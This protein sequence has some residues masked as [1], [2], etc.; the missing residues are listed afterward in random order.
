MNAQTT[1]WVLAALLA[2]ALAG[3]A[4]AAALPK[5]FFMVA[6]G[7]ANAVRV[8]TLPPGPDSDVLLPTQRLVL[9]TPSDPGGVT[10]VDGLSS[11]CDTTVRWLSPTELYLRLSEAYA[12]RLKASDGAVLGGVTLRIDLHTD[13]VL[14]RVAGPD[15]AY[16][17]VEIEKC[18]TQDWGLYL[19]RSGDPDYDPSMDLGWGDPHL[20]GGLQGQFPLEDI[21]WTGPRS[22]CVVVAQ[23]PF[24]ARFRSKVGPVR[25]EWEYDTAYHRPPDSMS[26]APVGQLTWRE[27][28]H[29]MKILVKSW[30]KPSKKI[31]SK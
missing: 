6:P 10:L 7:R 3:A 15:G 11:L 25:F 12:P 19:R 16:V 24:G 30:L 28:F 13:Q 29:N 21:E 8:D 26:V 23:H 4:R 31:V 2:P 20:C 9:L 18:E 22:V 27:K 5:P 1:K 14:R 17:L